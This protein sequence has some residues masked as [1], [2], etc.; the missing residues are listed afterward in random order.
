MQSAAEFQ[1]S[2]DRFLIARGKPATLQR[3]SAATVTMSAALTVFMRGYGP[4]ELVAGTGIVQGDSMV[5]ISRAHLESTGWPGGSPRS[6]DFLLVDGT[7]RRVV[8]AAVR[9]L[10]VGFDLQVRG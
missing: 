6:G 1:A 8:A 5:V 2:L 10:D 9:P 3:R 4:D 7:T